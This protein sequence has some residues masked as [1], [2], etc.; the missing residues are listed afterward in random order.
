MYLGGMGVPRDYVNAFRWFERSAARGNVYSTYS[1]AV[2]A[3]GV[4]ALRAI[5]SWRG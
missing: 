1:V 5:R 2:M 3:E 4:S